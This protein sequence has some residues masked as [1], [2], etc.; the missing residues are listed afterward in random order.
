MKKLLVIFLLFFPVHGA[1]ANEIYLTCM[2]KFHDGS[3]EPLGFVID[4]VKG[5]VKN[6]SGAE[7]PNVFIDDKVIRFNLMKELVAPGYIKMQYYID[8]YTGKI[9]IYAHKEDG[10]I[11]TIKGN[12]KKFD[13]EEWRD[14]KF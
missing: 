5:K 11:I 8:R 14:K 10:V 1:W 12:C 9:S 4:L 3:E 2:V 13:I 7:H 6:E